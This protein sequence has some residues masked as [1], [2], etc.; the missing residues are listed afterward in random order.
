MTWP[1]TTPIG[2]AHWRWTT[3]QCRG[4]ENASLHGNHCPA[5]PNDGLLEAYASLENVAA[6]LVTCYS[7]ELEFD[8]LSENIGIPAANTALSYF[9]TR[10]PS[11]PVRPG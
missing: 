10:F 5:G 6:I 1:L 11:F 7:A 3:S 8:R 4:D 9:F 2:N